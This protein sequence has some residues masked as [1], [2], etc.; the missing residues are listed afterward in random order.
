MLCVSLIIALTSWNEVLKW[1]H[2]QL[3][4]IMMKSPGTRFLWCLLRKNSSVS[5]KFE[6]SQSDSTPAWFMLVAFHLLIH[7]LCFISLPPPL[8]PSSQF[9][10]ILFTHILPF[11]I[12]ILMGNLDIKHVSRKQCLSTEPSRNLWDSLSLGFI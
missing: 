10:Q 5:Y 2:G 7:L 12:H 1:K 8:C 6:I 9:T 3:I 11:I 4:F